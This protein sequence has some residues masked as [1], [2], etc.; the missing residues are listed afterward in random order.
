MLV[1][2]E[3]SSWL[4]Y[5]LQYT[6]GFTGW[7]VKGCDLK[8]GWGGIILLFPPVLIGFPQP[9]VGVDVLKQ[10]NKPVVYWRK[11]IKT[12]SFS[13]CMDKVK[14]S[15]CNSGILSVACIKVTNIF[16]PKSDLKEWFFLNTV[17]VLSLNFPANLK[18]F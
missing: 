13:L 8:K 15:S 16:I 12:C 7:W 14:K 4:V 10:V 17:K 9:W 1:L 6:I 5:R 2:R 11:Y 3:Q 18:K